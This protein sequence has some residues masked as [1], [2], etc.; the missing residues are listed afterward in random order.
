M[1]RLLTTLFLTT[2]AV[3]ATGTGGCPW[4]PLPNEAFGPP[5]TCPNGATP[6]LVNLTYNEPE[7][8]LG[9]GSI[10]DMTTFQNSLGVEFHCPT[11]PKAFGCM[12]F[13]STIADTTSDPDLK[14]PKSSKCVP[15]L[16]N[17]L[18]IQ[19]NGDGFGGRPGTITP[20]DSVDGG[21]IRLEFV[22]GCVFI[23]TFSH[24][25]NQRREDLDITVRVSACRTFAFG[26]SSCSHCT[27]S[28]HHM[29]LCEFSQEPVHI[30]LDLAPVGDGKYRDVYVG[31]DLNT[32][33]RTF[34]IDVRGSMGFPGLS[35]WKCPDDPPVHGGGDP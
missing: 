30:S 23:N 25:D 15:D 6:Q 1:M 34:E 21:I 13:N 9:H 4:Q 14:S 32:C 31:D 2:A 5:P 29:P 19:E 22:D 10:V 20:D 24:I 35:W 26:E 3:S 12:I 11:G 17:I 7:F 28:H 27:S 8:G 18:I 16:G 33:T